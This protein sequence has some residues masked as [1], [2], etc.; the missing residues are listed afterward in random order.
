MNI[1]LEK[2]YRD[3]CD[4]G[5][6]VQFTVEFTRHAVHFS[7]FYHNSAVSRFLIGWCAVVNDSTDNGADAMLTNQIARKV[8]DNACLFHQSRFSMQHSENFLRIC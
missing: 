5:F 1:A 4:I 2:R 6:R 8:M 3:E 7:I